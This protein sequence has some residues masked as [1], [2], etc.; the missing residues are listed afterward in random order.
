MVPSKGLSNIFTDGLNINGYEITFTPSV[1]ASSTLCTVF[2]FWRN[3]SFRLNKY[4]TTKNSFLISINYI[5]SSGRLNLT[6]NRITKN[7]V[8]PSNFDGKKVAIWLTE[9]FNSNVTKFHLAI[10]PQP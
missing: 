3:R 2:K 6:V 7:I 10:T 1:A 9:N 8:I 4:L 5:R